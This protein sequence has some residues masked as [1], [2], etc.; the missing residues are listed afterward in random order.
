MTFNEISFEAVCEKCSWNWRSRSNDMPRKCPKCGAY[1]WNSG[2]RKMDY[3]IARSCGT[4]PGT[5]RMQFCVI[6]FIDNPK[7]VTEDRFFITRDDIDTYLRNKRFPIGSG[8]TF[9][10]NFEIGEDLQL[11][12]IECKLI[13]GHEATMNNY[14]STVYLHYNIKSFYE[15]QKALKKYEEDLKQKETSRS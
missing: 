7:T 5:D 9:I 2:T 8:L 4:E 3:I 6:D 15:R 10:G 14:L 1:A 11:K 13:Y 12:I